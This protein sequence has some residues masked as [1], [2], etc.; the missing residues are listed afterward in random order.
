V[1]QFIDIAERLTLEEELRQLGRQWEGIFET[2]GQ[3]AMILAPD[4]TILAVNRAAE[5]AAG[6]TADRMIG[7]PCAPI[8]HGLACPPDGCPFRRLVELGEAEGTVETVL[9][10]VG[11]T[12]LVTCT[13]VCDEEG[14][15]EK[16]VHLATEITDRVR[17]EQALRLANDKLALIS[18]VT[19][20][21]LRNRLM[22]LQGYVRMAERETDPDRRARYRRL[23]NETAGAMEQILTFAADYE[24]VGAQ[25]PEWQRLDEV[26]G[27]ALEEVEID[28]IRL[29]VEN[30]EVEVLADHLLRKVFSN[31]MDNSVRYGGTVTRIRISAHTDGEALVVSQFTLYGDTRKG[32]RPSWTDA[33]EPT[34]AAER[35]EAFAC[36]LESRG[37]STV[38]RGVFGA[39]MQV[40]LV[41]DGPVTL[42]LE[43]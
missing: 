9:D 8:F 26:V 7:R 1:V 16:V 43:A 36:A 40:N 41:N 2:I 18:N 35:V 24:R 38:G 29:E 14:R 17:N 3:P 20:H 42:I 25:A 27:A 23:I 39:H 31:L 6:L 37:V 4:Q 34:V 11:G 32:R 22:G 15:L 21:D 10:A 19:R 33:A 28:G 13:P 5:R 12:Y 30:G